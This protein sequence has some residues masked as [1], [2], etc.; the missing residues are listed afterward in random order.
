[1]KRIKEIVILILLLTLIST[2]FISISQGIEGVATSDISKFNVVVFYY[3]WLNT[4]NL[5]DLDF[6][7]LVFSGSENI[8]TNQYDVIQALRDKGVKVYAYLHDGETPVG[9]GSSFREKVVENNTGTLDERVTYWKDYIKGLI[10]RYVSKVD[11]V[12]LDECDPSYFDTANPDNENLQLFSQGLEEI[13]NY[14]HSKGLKVF[15]NGVR[16]YAHLGD[17]YLWE[18]F[19]AVYDDA[20]GYHL[21]TEFYSTSSN[22]P[23]EWVNG[24]AKYEYL[25]EHNLLGKTIALSYA[26]LEHLENAKYGYYMARILGL[27]GWGFSD[28]DVYA[29]GGPI[30]I[31][32]VYEVG[33]AITPPSIDK[34]DKVAS[35]IFMA[36][37]VVVDLATPSLLTPFDNYKPYVIDGKTIE[38]S[39]LI[40]V[41]KAG[42][43]SVLKTLGYVIT[44]RGIQIYIEAS[45]GIQ[46]SNGL[47]HI[48]VDSDGNPATGFS[49]KGNYGAE[50][51]VEV[52]NST[53][54]SG[55]ELFAYLHRYI[56]V[57]GW[58]WN[59]SQIEV[60][61]I[62]YSIPSS[63]SL[64]IELLI[65][66]L[67][68]S[69]EEVYKLGSR[70]SV[71]TVVNWGDDAVYG[72]ITIE[73]VDKI[74]PTIYDSSGEFEEYYPVITKLK[75]EKRKV[76]FTAN[77]PSGTLT[78]YTIYVPFTKVAK[79]TKNGSPLPRK[80]TS[81]FS[82]EG[83]YVKA[84]DN[85]AEVIVRALHESPVT[86]TIY[87]ISGGIASLG[88]EPIDK[89]T[90]V[91]PY[92][93]LIGILS[94]MA[95]YFVRRKS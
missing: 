34:D 1:M 8:M 5:L 20:N 75:M 3:G 85:Y 32:D 87:G 30:S 9:L 78:T 44:P 38:Y 82:G 42:A 46:L 91:L 12:F 77:A 64:N 48:Y 23:Y 90:L 17:Y 53:T 68:P 92:M 80:D 60:V 31:L 56:G 7:I 4:S 16:A 19:I 69:G 61:S 88:G 71:A 33:P 2:P 13:V 57:G 54:D 95:L 67:T 35:R 93:T 29:N 51:L 83:Y 58:D 89:V 14:A 81:N 27:A 59:W 76:T 18:D 94:V 47:I 39:N 43:S 24:I 25:K 6:D 65:P 45:W 15:I 21:D 74:P 66:K 52:V 40:S 72:N 49:G 10:D 28:I 62:A 55:F 36:G 41:N 11:G 26:D 63:Q 22:N 70:F 50:Y 86:I 37:E 73:D 79:V 84:Y